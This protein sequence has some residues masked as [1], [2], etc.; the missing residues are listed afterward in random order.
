M[1][2][3][4]L[5]MENLLAQKRMCENDS[6]LVSSTLTRVTKPVETSKKAKRDRY[7]EA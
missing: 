6:D 4:V 1:K 7:K 2:N 3:Q 5:Q